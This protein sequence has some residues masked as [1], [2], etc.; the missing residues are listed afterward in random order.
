M[1]VLAIETSCDET[2]ASVAVDGTSVLSS[3]V[4]SQIDVHKKYGGVVPE[5][6][7]RKHVEAISIVIEEAL[8]QA[9][10]DPQ[11]IEGIGVT[12]GPGLIGSLIVGIAAA[13]GMALALNRPICGVNHLHGHLFAAH[14]E[15][16]DIR[17]PFVGLVVSGG[18]TSLYHVK[19]PL[20]IELI[21]KT[22][23]DAAG[24][25]FD[26]VAKLLGLGYPGG[27]AIEQWAKDVDP[28]ALEFR[29]PRA[30][31]EGDELDFSF[32]GLKTAVLRHVE[33]RFDI[34]R[35]VAIP[36]SFHP[37]IEPGTADET[38]DAVRE[39]ASAFQDAVTEVLA[40]KGFRAAQKHGVS[41]LVVCGGVAANAALRR[42]VAAT[43]DKLGIE[44]IFP[45]LSLCTDNAAMIAARA[46]VL[47]SLGITDNLD[48]GAKSRW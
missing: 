31:V 27:V 29:F 43:G 20:E 10:V 38:D 26:K 2:A 24:E 8:L 21:G 33:E 36:G 17:F 40:I 4:V 1:L 23:D 5:L 9:D 46:D 11:K 12:R 6:A 39:I 18:H 19:G 35:N 41:Q 16:D 15:R 48:F 42:R 14:L 3:V 45:S 37:L 22:R 30:L 34:S 13:K 32:S 44:P 47:L 7:S 28:A 25:A